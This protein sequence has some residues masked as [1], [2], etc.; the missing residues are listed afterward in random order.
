MVISKFAKLCLHEVSAKTRP[1]S[2]GIAM[3]S[4]G[5]CSIQNPP[6]IVNTV[7]VSPAASNDIGYV[8]ILQMPGPNMGA[9]T[10]LLA[11]P[12]AAA[13]PPGTSG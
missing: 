13:K 4:R 5:S 7:E 2:P 11:Q 12:A 1:E 8:M 3:G 6:D 9:M 10:N